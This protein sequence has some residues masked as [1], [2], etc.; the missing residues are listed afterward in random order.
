MAWLHQTLTRKFVVLLVGFLILQAA[1]LAG[2]IFG[3]LHVGERGGLINEAGRQR[4]RTL[5]LAHQVR[6]AI[7]A[8]E[9]KTGQQD[10][11]RRTVSRYESF[12]DSQY[13]RATEPHAP[14]GVRVLLG[15]AR[16]AWR[17]DLKPLL[18]GIDPAQARLARTRLVRYE[19]LV[20][21]QIERLD[22]IVDLLEQDL[23]ESARHL[24]VFQAAVLAFTLGLGIAGLIMARE[25]VT[26]PMRRLIRATSAI[27]DGT[28]DQRVETASRDEIGE[29]GATFNRMA[30][31]IRDNTA[32]IKALNRVAVAITSSLSLERIL[33]DVMR[34]G[35][36]LTGAH[37]SCIALYD[38]ERQRFADWVTH[39]LSTE[40]VQNMDF[41]PGGVGDRAFTGGDYILSHDR[42]RAQ[43]PLGQPARKEGIQSFICMP[44]ISREDRLG[45]IYF[46]RKDRDYFQPEEIDTLKT[47]ASL[48]ASAIGNARLYTRTADLALT[49]A[50]T[51]L[52]NRRGFEEHLEEELRRAARYER[53]LTLMLLDIDFFKRIN[54]RFGHQA[55]DAVLSQLADVLSRT[56]RDTD[57]VAR[58]G[59]EEFAFLLPETD[60]LGAKQ[61]GERTRQAVE[62]NRFRLPG[63]GELNLT[64]SIGL[65]GFPAC[66]DNRDA[67]I[68][69]ADQALYSAKQSGRNRIT[70]YEEML[71]AQFER[72]HDKIAQLLRQDVVDFHTVA[73]AVDIKAAYSRNHTACVHEH[74]L[75]LGEALA[76]SRSQLEILDKAGFLHDIGM[77][78]VPESILNKSSALSEEELEIVRRHPVVGAELLEKVPA[79]RP[80][81]SA[82][83]HHH[84]RFD[85]GGYPDGLRGTA[86]PYLAR[87]VAVVDTYCAMRSP[88]PDRRPLTDE[89][90]RQHLAAEAGEQLDPDIVKTF[91]E[92]LDRGERETSESP[93]P[94][95][96]QG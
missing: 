7:L 33:D 24:A 86:I 40:F 55:G 18:L 79:L 39:G 44:L 60:S 3:I 85:G 94:H 81:V 26:R 20:P 61:L 16:S 11:F 87:I 53:A 30:G 27:A 92:L 6:R 9:W 31:A 72:Q 59:G 63:G 8:G 28:Y 68:E 74:A 17:E 67:L 93:G 56:I 76:L 34:Q 2:G 91:L 21:E 47:L 45:V 82:V 14:S 22:E 4:M 32:R 70:S 13:A 51:R 38:S 29:L 42:P 52:S 96:S 46:Y 65:A 15:E 71:T 62:R 89:E 58:Y 1:Q 23:R 73:S 66:A 37:A 48:A 83:L 84:E 95:R 36:T 50:L 57:R 35:T 10:A 19:G 77:I 5:L 25:I 49:D 78:I 69:R 75:Q 88:R 64:V 54:D 43:Y 80:I 90:A 12:I 41:R